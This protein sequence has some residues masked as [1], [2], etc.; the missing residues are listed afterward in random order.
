M[1]FG[2][3]SLGQFVRNGITQ[4]LEMSWKT[5]LNMKK[6]SLTSSWSLSTRLNNSVILRT[7]GVATFTLLPLAEYLDHDLPMQIKTR[8][9]GQ[10]DK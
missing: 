4:T 7:S 5:D 9:G 2:F 3:D 10:N 1:A 8:A 6:S